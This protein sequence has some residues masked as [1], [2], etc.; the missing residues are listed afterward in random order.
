MMELLFPMSTWAF[1]CTEYILFVLCTGATLA[2]HSAP[3]LD[4]G[5][6]P[7]WLAPAAD[8]LRHAEA[9]IFHASA[10]MGVDSGVLGRV[11]GS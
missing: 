10:G 2:Q 3:E 6:E 4:P 9:L 8:A 11:H 5:Q 7:A 1:T